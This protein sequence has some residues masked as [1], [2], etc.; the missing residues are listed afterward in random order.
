MDI[1][2]NTPKPEAPF[3]YQMR[4]TNMME[5]SKGIAW[6][7]ELLRE[8]KQVGTI[9]QAGEGGADDVRIFKEADRSQ[10]YEDVSKAFSSDEENAT[11]WLLEQEE[12]EEGN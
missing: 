9:T 10:W 3:P 8:G 12:A 1:I 7:A 4:T 2:F 6:T 11:W 5:H